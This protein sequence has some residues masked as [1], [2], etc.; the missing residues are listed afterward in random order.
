MIPKTNQIPI[1]GSRGVPSSQP[2][3]EKPYKS[4]E[5]SLSDGGA[6]SFSATGVI[7][8]ARFVDYKSTP[9]GRHS[10]DTR[11]EADSPFEAAFQDSVEA[12]EDSKKSIAGVSFSDEIKGKVSL[13]LLREGG[14]KNEVLLSNAN[15]VHNTNH[16][17]LRT[18]NLEGADFQVF[19]TVV[20]D[21]EVASNIEP[22]VGKQG[23][24]LE[25][26]RFNSNP[27]YVAVHSIENGFRVFA[28][29]KNMSE[30][31]RVEFQEQARKLFE[32]NGLPLVDFVM[33]DTNLKNI[34][35]E[36]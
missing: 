1:T 10:I 9:D 28:R 4:F 29:V 20:Q 19:K 35:N 34:E 27:I 2:I 24:N 16:S 17:F 18:T 23:K 36:G 6:E 26:I 15:V 13:S 30:T 25:K 7:G 33:S 21:V 8:H 22:Y 14:L 31:E 5:Q 3:D 32:Q 12:L 11:I